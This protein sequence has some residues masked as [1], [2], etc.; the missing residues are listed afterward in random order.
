MKLKDNP[1]YQ[2]VQLII[3]ENMRY[4]IEQ[5]TREENAYSSL[6]SLRALLHVLHE[7]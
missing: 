3:R 1:D 7:I 2:D 6:D 4:L 5:V